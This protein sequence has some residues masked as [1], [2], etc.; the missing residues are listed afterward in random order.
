[1]VLLPL[2]F[3]GSVAQAFVWHGRTRGRAALQAA[4]VTGVAVV[5]ITEF[6]SLFAL[7]TRWPL[8]LAWAFSAGIALLAGAKGR[9]V[10]R[11]EIGEPIRAAGEGGVAFWLL[12]ATLLVVGV[13]LLIALAAAPNNW[14][15]M[16]YHLARVCH[17]MANRSVRP[18]PTNIERQLWS[19]PWAEFLILHFQI[20]SGGS[21]RFANLVQ[22]LAFVGSL[23]AVVAIVGKLGGGRRLRLAAAL[24]AATTPEVVLQSTSTQNDLTVGFWLACF[25]FFLVSSAKVQTPRDPDLLWAGLALGLATCTKPTAFFYALPFLLWLLRRKLRV[26]RKTALRA[27]LIFAA[28]AVALDAGHVM[29]NLGVYRNPLG[30][31]ALLLH[32]RHDFSAAGIISDLS[33]N[34]TTELAT[35]SPRWNWLLARG[36]ASFHKRILGLDLT[37]DRDFLW[38]LGARASYSTHE[39]FASNPL[40]MLCGVGALAL[41]LLGWRRLRGEVLAFLI[42]AWSGFLLL[43][44]LVNW[45]PW[46][47]RL[48]VPFFV[49]LAPSLALVI[50]D[51]LSAPW[52][53]LLLGILFLAATPFLF[54]N[55]SRP[56][57]VQPDGL[58]R[59]VL[60]AARPEQYFANRP[61]LREP[62][63][64]AVAWL[65]RSG[66]RRAAL[67]GPEDL[68]EYPLW[69]LGRLQGVDLTFAHVLVENPSGRISPDDADDVCALVAVEQPLDWRP[70]G[71]KFGDFQEVWRRDPIAIFAPAGKRPQLR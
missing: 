59:S 30:T 42:C 14:D 51:R 53:N 36:L 17:W 44:L 69:Q 58:V 25:G 34:V 26:G 32:G 5:L 52:M 12:P 67:K 71:R 13:T 22:W 39:D 8:A 54:S 16:T 60:S 11:G 15:S 37:A 21:D 56:L 43:G 61:E 10:R 19:N 66:C 38:W 28:S 63:E 9:W 2:L 47:T 41:A 49:L 40:Q 64:D 23:C 62:Y 7:L 68:W 31:P 27:V 1:M 33:R 3:W 65:A 24:L 20:L 29:R 4:V 50:G 46:V 57:L 18:Y 55:R 70:K 48:H 45:Q 35:P 6:L